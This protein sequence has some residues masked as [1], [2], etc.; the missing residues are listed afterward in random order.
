MPAMVVRFVAESCNTSRWGGIPT[1]SSFNGRPS[2][3]LIFSFSRYGRSKKSADAL[4]GSS[5]KRE[6]LSNLISL[7]PLSSVA[8]SHVMPNHE[9]IGASDNQCVSTDAPENT[10]SKS[11]SETSPRHQCSSYNFQLTCK[12]EIMKLSQCLPFLRSGSACKHSIIGCLFFAFIVICSGTW[13]T[14]SV[15]RI[16]TTYWR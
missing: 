5:V 16:L 10:F 8:L 2:F 14:G 4:D 11:Q 6:L 13:L 9:Q 3:P 15:D 7:T 12:D 1:L